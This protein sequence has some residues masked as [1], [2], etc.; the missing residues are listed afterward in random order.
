[1]E[2]NTTNLDKTI[3]HWASIDGYLN[4]QV[5]WFGRVVNTK[6]GRILKAGSGT[7]G[8]RYVILSK[9]GKP[10]IHYIHKL[11]A[12]EW[13]AN[14]DERPCV[15]HIDND[16]ANNHH[17]NLRWA[18]LSENSRNM[19]KHKDGSSAFKGVSFTKNS[20]KWRARIL[21]PGKQLHLGCFTSEREA[22]EA[23]NAAAVLHYTNFAK[24]N[25]FE[26]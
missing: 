23:Y 12:R 18:T 15:D 22:A 14:P 20:G 13:R 10:K 16:K 19:K 6:T 25:K 4:Y 5:S 17:E 21:L 24:L 8:Y 1:M 26:D 2:V 9:N 11:V 3:E 7:T